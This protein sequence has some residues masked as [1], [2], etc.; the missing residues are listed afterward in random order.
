ME[1]T[2]K[3]RPKAGTIEW[4]EALWKQAFESA[5]DKGDFFNLLAMQS[6]NVKRLTERVEK[7]ESFLVGLVLSE[8]GDGLV[9]VRGTGHLKECRISSKLETTDDECTC[10]AIPRKRGA[11]RG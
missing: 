1:L 3:R 7:L 4:H 9:I 2:R 8:C 5:T 11:R 6:Q 10:G